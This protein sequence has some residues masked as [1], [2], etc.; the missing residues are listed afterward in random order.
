MGGILCYDALCCGDE[1]HNSW[2]Q[3]AVE[4]DVYS[5]GQYLFGRRHRSSTCSSVVHNPAH[6][7]CPPHAP[8]PNI[9]V[10]LTDNARAPSMTNIYPRSCPVTPEFPLTTPHYPIRKISDPLVSCQ[11]IHR[12]RKTSAPQMSDPYFHFHG[13][14]SYSP[15]STNTTTTS[16]VYVARKSGGGQRS[17]S[18]G[19]PVAAS[20]GVVVHGEG[21][22]SGKCH[23]HALVVLQPHV[24]YPSARPSPVFVLFILYF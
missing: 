5:P 18:G 14:N 11:T 10:S 24:V 19:P 22:I 9:T 8:S 15:P 21:F 7:T 17:F 23:N 12:E 2:T 3:S 20:C 4:G 13:S 16:A 6:L 1:G